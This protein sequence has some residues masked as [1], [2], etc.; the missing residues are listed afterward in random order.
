MPIIARCASGRHR[1]PRSSAISRRAW[2]QAPRCRGERRRGRRRPL[3]SR[4]RAAQVHERF[5]AGPAPHGDAPRRRRACGRPPHAR[6]PAGTRP[7]RARRRSAVRRAPRASSRS[8]PVRDRGTPRAK[9]CA[10]CSWPEARMLIANAP[11]REQ[12]V[13]GGMPAE[14]DAEEGRLERERDERVDGQ[15]RGLVRKLDGD[16][17]DGRRGSRSRA[18]GRGQSRRD[19]NNRALYLRPE[20]AK[21]W[22]GRDRR[23]F[24]NEGEGRLRRNKPL[25]L[26]AASSAALVLVGVLAGGSGPASQTGRRSHRPLPSS[27]S[28]SAAKRSHRGTSC[29]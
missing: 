4:V 10:R 16:D 21:S 18:A 13:Q 27:R 19:P 3:R 23:A 22:L 26:V 5:A 15:A 7:S 28:R 9:C 24:R 29:E 2:S 14:S 8:R 11:P 6:R 12:F 17:R 25:A 1:P 20:S